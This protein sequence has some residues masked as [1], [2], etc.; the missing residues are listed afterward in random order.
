MSTITLPCSCEI[1]GK[2]IWRVSVFLG[3]QSK[4]PRIG[5]NVPQN[6]SKRPLCKKYWSKRPQ[7]IFYSI[8]LQFWAYGCW[9]SLFPISMSPTANLWVQNTILMESLQYY[10]ILGLA[11]IKTLHPRDK[12]M[13]KRCRMRR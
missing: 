12:I 3:L 9:F 4:R 5:Q 8:H 1:T 10:C 13:H 6:W 11:E 7:I 2:Q